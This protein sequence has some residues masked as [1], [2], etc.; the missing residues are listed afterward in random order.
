MPE[1]GLGSPRLDCQSTTNANE[2]DEQIRFEICVADNGNRYEPK[3]TKQEPV[4]ISPP[5][6]VPIYICKVFNC[7]RPPNINNQNDGNEKPAQQKP[8]VAGP[9]FCKCAAHC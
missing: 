6:A 3:D 4:D 1:I 7:K 8:A 5:C 9:E 2:D